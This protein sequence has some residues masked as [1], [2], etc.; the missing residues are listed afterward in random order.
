MK[1]GT[2]E[3]SRFPLF[4]ALDTGGGS[5]ADEL[6]LCRDL[7]VFSRDEQGG[8]L[9][10]RKPTPRRKGLLPLLGSTTSPSWPWL[11]K[12]QGQCHT[13]TQLT[14]RFLS[15]PLLRPVTMPFVGRAKGRCAQGPLERWP[16][17]LPILSMLLSLRGVQ[18]ADTQC[19]A[20]W[21][22]GQE[23]SVG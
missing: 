7:C 4:L 5:G 15:L 21:P 8:L 10:F 2:F 17:G 3:V 22:S 11:S 12:G 1:P 20:C 6:P 9:P 14:P 16:A 18:S 19:A 13:H 23:E